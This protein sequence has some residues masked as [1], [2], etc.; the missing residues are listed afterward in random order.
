FQTNSSMVEKLYATI[1]QHV[2]NV[3]NLWD[4]YAGSATIGIFLRDHANQIHCFENNPANIADAEQNIAHNAAHNVHMQGGS[5]EDRL[6]S[7]FIREQGIP[8]C[9][10]VD[11]PRAGLSQQARTIIQGV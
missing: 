4:L 7:S 3:S 9:V 1:G 10:I 2:G 6:T 8:D 11:P 5:V